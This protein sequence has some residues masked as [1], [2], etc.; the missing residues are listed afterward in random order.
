M[1][2]D[3]YY[4]IVYK[5]LAYLYLQLKG[6][7]PVEERMVSNENALFKINESYWRYIIKHLYEDGY[8]EGISITKI[9]GNEVVF[10]NLQDMMI[11]PKGIDYLCN[12]S[13]FEK[14][15]DFLRDIKDIT[16]FI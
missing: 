1:A 4:V 9:F 3:D 16:P 13:L 11:T 2:R 10:D 12:N 15:K 8:I 14:A 6:G 5:L 7:K